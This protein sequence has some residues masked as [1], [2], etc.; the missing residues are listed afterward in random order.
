MVDFD[1]EIKK[2]HSINMREIELN[3][4]MIDDNIKKSIILYNTAVGELKKGNF[5][6][7]I[8]DFKKALT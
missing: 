2:I 4:Y 3:R 7:V 1:L 5:D 8:N 6:L